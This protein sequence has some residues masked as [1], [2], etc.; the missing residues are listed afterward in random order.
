MSSTNRCSAVLATLLVLVS[1]PLSG[2]ASSSGAQHPSRQADETKPPKEGLG[3]IIVAGHPVTGSKATGIS[4]IPYQR[5]DTDGALYAAVTGFRSM[6]F[7][8]S[9]LEGVYDDILAPAPAHAGHGP[10]DV[11]TTID[12]AVQK[13]AA[14][15]LRGRKGAAVALDAQSGQIRA[16]VSAPSYD[17]SVFSGLSSADNDAWLRLNNDKDMPLL[18]RALRDTVEPGETFQVVVAA[19]ALNKGLY[20]SV[21]DPTHSPDPYTPPGRTSPLASDFTHCQNASIRSALK[22]SCANVFASMAVDVGQ[23]GLATMAEAFGFN[24]DKLLT[25]IRPAASVYPRGQLSAASLAD[26]GNGIEGV[27]ATPLQMARVMAVLDN[28]G[29]QTQP[30]LVTQI[31]H[32]DGS[33]EK[34]K[35]D[36]GAAKQV[37]EPNVANQLRS[38]LQGS[39]SPPLGGETGWA[40]RSGPANR[41]DAAAWSVSFT[42]SGD[43][44][45]MAIAVVVTVPA[46]STDHSSDEA[47]AVHVAQEMSQAASNSTHS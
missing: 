37:L 14:D 30:E 17:P 18:D 10:S 5:T 8:R 11:V 19:A 28:G 44:R 12:P 23:D 1:A 7:G 33:V 6:A 20:K 24:D 25:P 9:G 46:T 3:N 43:G 29:K 47:G 36:T 26:T 27:T 31:I 45:P 41:G 16:L 32:P 2:C 15:G 39:A 38:A 13:A 21:D 40:P 35:S 42:R 34:P 4:K 22:Y